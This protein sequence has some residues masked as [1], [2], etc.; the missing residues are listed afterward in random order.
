MARISKEKQNE[1]RNKILEVSK[2]SFE[3]NGYEETSTKKIAQE[4]GIAEGTLFNYFE[5]KGE[6]FLES[7]TKG[8]VDFSYDSELK[9]EYASEILYNY[10]EKILKK[11]IIFPKRLI[12]E[13]GISMIKLARKKPKLTKQLAELDYQYIRNIENICIELQERKVIKETDI[14]FLCETLY[15]TIMY[16][17]MMYLYE[18][19]ITRTMF[20]GNIKLKFKKILIMIGSE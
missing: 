8:I 7:F 18:K 14:K 5:S 2:S 3:K 6:I 11:T 4:V 13:L 16:E 12:T 10:T 9:G 19:E 15:S 20:L 1:I 17:L